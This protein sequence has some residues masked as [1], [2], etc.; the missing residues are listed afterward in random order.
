M[1]NFL[2]DEYDFIIVG[3]GSAGSVIA[4]RLSEV[5]NWKILLLEAG[6]PETP[7]MGIPLVS[8][9]LIKTV[10]KTIIKSKG[11]IAPILGL[12]HFCRT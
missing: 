11:M 4:N 1:S 8:I 6:I 12:K 2:D 7:F 9:I 5:K 3:S 10:P